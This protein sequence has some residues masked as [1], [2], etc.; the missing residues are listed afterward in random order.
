MGLNT[1]NSTLESLGAGNGARGQKNQEKKVSKPLPFTC[2]N[3]YQRLLTAL[4]PLTH[5]APHQKPFPV[6]ESNRSEE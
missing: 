6:M 2:L 4:T 1:W 5:H 3:E